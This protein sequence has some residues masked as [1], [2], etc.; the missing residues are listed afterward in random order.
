MYINIFGCDKYPQGYADLVHKWP[1]LQCKP[2]HS[3]GLGWVA[4]PI[5][6]ALVIIGGYILP[7]VLIGIVIV[8]F[9]QVCVWSASGTRALHALHVAFLFVG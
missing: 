7:T 5:F 3:D 8:S 6:V 9:T 4:V 2:R 1:T